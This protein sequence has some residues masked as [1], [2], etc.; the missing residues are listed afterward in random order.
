MHFPGL[1]AGVV[2]VAALLVAVT[3]AGPLFLASA[4]DRS[5]ALELAAL[6]GRPALTVS[7][8]GPLTDAF[9]TNATLALRRALA[10]LPD[11]RPLQVTVSGITASARAGGITAPVTVVAR[12]GVGRHVDAVGPVEAEGL[13]VPVSLAGRI[14]VGA[15]S[16]LTL[17]ASGRTVRV[18]VAGRYR[19][20]DP[21][22]L[23][24]DWRSTPGIADADTGGI[25]LGTPG[26]AIAALS[27]VVP[28]ARFQ[29]VSPLAATDVSLRDAGRLAAGVERVRS[30]LAEQ[31]KPPGSVLGGTIGVAPFSE[32]P[33]AGA[34][35]DA[36]EARSELV[37]STRAISLAAVVIA[38]AAAAA[39]G[40]YATRRRRVQASML[41]VR[42][43]GPIGQGLLAAAEA[44]LPVAI[45]GA[46]GWVAA[47][48]LVR[49]LGPSGGIDPVARTEALGLALCVS[50]IGLGLYGVAAG[51]ATLAD[52]D[53]PRGKASRIAAR[54]PWEPVALVLAAAALYEIR[55][56]SAGAGGPDVLLLAFPWLVVAGLAGL[57]ARGVPP[58]V[59]ALRGAVP[60]RRTATYFAVRRL[61]SAPKTALVTVTGTAV[62]VGVLVYAGT[63]SATVDRTA[64]SKAVAASGSDLAL[65]LAARTTSGHVSTLPPP[66]AARSSTVVVRLGTGRLSQG[67]PADVLAVD[68]AT[69]ERGAQWDPA[70][71]SESLGSLLD[72]LTGPAAKRIPVIVAGGSGRSTA[73]LVVQGRP[74]AVR[75]VDRVRAWPGMR[76]PDR[77]L[78]VVD[79]D[80]IVRKAPPM[81][82]LRTTVAELWERGDPLALRSRLEDAGTDTGQAVLIGDVRRRP[83]LL[84]L[85][86]AIQLLLALGIAA[87]VVAVAAAVLSM[88]AR[89]ES[90]DLAYALGRRM[91][92]A[93]RTHRR[94]LSLELGAL[95][96]VAAV[97]GSALAVG[98]S[99]LVRARLEVVPGLP[100]PT[101]FTL[102]WRMLAGIAAGTVVVA[103]AGGWFV[104]RRARR[105]NP[106]EVLRVAG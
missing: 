47:T 30:R 65:P 27:G 78:V 104:Q 73:G 79:R 61:A 77:A 16:R 2:V 80:A 44:V 95:L 58:A 96:A 41:S 54:L 94:V 40:V 35:S 20:L 19:D 37:A 7:T 74:L 45:G 3:A 34:V 52:R 100:G 81:L 53:A 69:F 39:A 55:S 97:L 24:A 84:A 49:A 75:V 18:P 21:R 38:L 50:A 87:A 82:G 83:D 31:D 63:L 48:E 71:S 33:L 59:A 14:G 1:F 26:S 6:D 25:L 62:A 99:L 56:R 23:P 90:R 28:V 46:V 9:R 64:E 13:L 29:F 76:D 8:Y 4:G 10:G 93:D 72:D 36:S 89:Q 5:A 98:A 92:L 70:F 57:I 67:G 103:V 101:V 17:E 68:P 105:T 11:L 60:P 15:G 22:R 43:M 106:A 86:W 88:Q 66:G 12:E 32:S 51:I 91:G 85:T 102:P 42:G